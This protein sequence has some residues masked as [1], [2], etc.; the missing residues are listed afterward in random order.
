MTTGKAKPVIQLNLNK[1][2]QPAEVEPEAIKTA[3]SSQEIA[4]VTY[5]LVLNVAMQKTA[6]D[7]YDLMGRIPAAIYDTKLIRAAL[8]RAVAK[9]HIEKQ[10]NAWNSLVWSK[11]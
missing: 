1:Q 2:E 6:F 5:G 4:D 8:K 7:G 10:G 11:K 3:L 9:G